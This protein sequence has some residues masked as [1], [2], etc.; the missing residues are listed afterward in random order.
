[1]STSMSVWLDDQKKRVA[2][3]DADDQRTSSR[4]LNGI[5]NHTVCNLQ[6]AASSEEQRADELRLKVNQFRD[7]FDYIIIDTKGAA[8]MT[9]SVAVIKS[10]IT[11]IPLQPSASDLWA[12]E[13]ALATVRISQEATG[14]SPHATLILN[15]TN[16]RDVGAL[17]VRRLA[18]EFGIKVASTNIKRLNAYR[19]APGSDLA[20][21]QLLGSRGKKACNRLE[22]LFN[23]LLV[24]SLQK[25]RQNDKTYKTGERLP[26]DQRT[27]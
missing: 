24:E 19:D 17:H 5:P 22:R 15:F 2:L 8:G 27:Y 7:D 12:I 18:T 14:G 11:C 26:E 10:D 1:M 25:Q 9:T 4:W 20:P 21:T 13:N 16:D 23:E 3:I 6:L